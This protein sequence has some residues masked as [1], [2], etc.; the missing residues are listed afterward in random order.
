[1]NNVVVN[2]IE[3][4]F[5]LSDIMSDGEKKDLLQDIKKELSIVKRQKT[6][7]KVF[8]KLARIQKYLSDI[9]DD[10]LDF[11]LLNIDFLLKYI[12]KTS[13]VEDSYEYY[14]TVKKILKK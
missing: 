14:T 4:K 8:N 13:D 10:E 1:M 11:L 7:K 2:E 3:N 9:D 5:L 6:E 12:K